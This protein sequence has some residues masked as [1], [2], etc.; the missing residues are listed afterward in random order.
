MKINIFWKQGPRYSRFC[1]VNLDIAK[2]NKLHRESFVNLEVW[3]E[4]KIYEFC[5]FFII[6]V[7]LKSVWVTHF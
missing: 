7:L 1:L 4:S 6:L 5:Y 3:N 2:A